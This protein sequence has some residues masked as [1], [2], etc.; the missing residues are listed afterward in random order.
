MKLLIM[1]CGIEVR[2]QIRA[3]QQKQPPNSYAARSNNL[4]KKVLREP[5]SGSDVFHYDESLLN[6]C[7][8]ALRQDGRL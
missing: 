2:F 3:S 4:K 7:R 1:N 5:K 6:Y 8:A